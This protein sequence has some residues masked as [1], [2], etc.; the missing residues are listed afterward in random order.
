M[1]VDELDPEIVQALK[2]VPT[3]DME[4]PFSRW[5]MAKASGLAPGAKVD[6]VERRIVREGA[7]RVRV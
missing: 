7:A 3:V 5:L 1:T 2:R 4:K 6:G